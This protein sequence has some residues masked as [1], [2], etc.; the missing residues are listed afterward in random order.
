M[1]STQTPPRAAAHRD[2]A[3]PLAGMR[4]G[5]AKESTPA[6]P[7][8]LS[9]ERRPL[10]EVTEH[11]YD[12]TT[13]DVFRFHECLSCGAWYLDPRPAASAL[14]IVYPPNYY[15][16]ASEKSQVSALPDSVNRRLFRARMAAYDRN[17]SLSPETTWLEIGVGQGEFLERLRKFD[18]VT[19]TVGIDFSERSVEIC[20]EKGLEA[21]AVSF[22]D[23]EPPAGLRFDVI[24]SS[25]VIE[26]VASPRAYMEKVH[27]LLKPGGIC[28]FDTP[29][30]DTWERKAFG[31]YWGGLHVPRHWSL[32]TPEAARKLGESTGFR[33]RETFFYPAVLFWIWSFHHTL[34]RF[35]GRRIADALFPSDHRINDAGLLGVARMVALTLFENLSIRLTG[36]SANMTVVFEKLL[37]S[38]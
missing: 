27:R 12:T 11:E 13:D 8:C 23:Y 10:M 1:S 20:R 9:T 33:Y 17:A 22:E 38:G 25:H 19:K 26:H 30:L 28:V 5:I 35:L 14:S 37:D 21:Y 29:S 6:C 24:H 2:A 15:A 7:C 34:E 36:K 3:S 31:A 16:Q 18:G 4:S 32:M